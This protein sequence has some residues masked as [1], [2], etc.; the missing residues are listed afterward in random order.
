[1][2][3]STGGYLAGFV[4]M[5]AIAGWAADRRP[6]PRSLSRPCSAPC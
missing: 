4:V 5:A 6:G 3:G 1:M 2:L